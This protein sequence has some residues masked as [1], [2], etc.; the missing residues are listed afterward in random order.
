MFLEQ[1]WK[2]LLSYIVAAVTRMQHTIDLTIDFD[3]V[4]VGS[5]C[6]PAWVTCEI[7]IHTISLLP[8]V[9]SLNHRLLQRL[10]PDLHPA[11]TIFWK[12]SFLDLISR[13]KKAFVI[14][15]NPV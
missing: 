13:V 12:K 2:S 4:H 14:Q 7:Y 1:S 15:S 5:I 3:V 9:F 8:V 6:S 11:V 10:L